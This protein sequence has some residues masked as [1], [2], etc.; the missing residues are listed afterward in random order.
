MDRGERERWLRLLEPSPTAAAH[1]SVRAVVGVRDGRRLAEEATSYRA[2]VRCAAL[3]LAARD[4]TSLPDYPALL[5]ALRWGKQSGMWWRSSPR[6]LL[7]YW[8]DERWLAR[9]LGDAE[10]EARAQRYLDRFRAAVLARE[11]A[12]PLL[13]LEEL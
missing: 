5:E 9:H 11:V 6:A 10:A 3:H 1:V 8:A 2:S 4:I 13:L 7:R 12:V